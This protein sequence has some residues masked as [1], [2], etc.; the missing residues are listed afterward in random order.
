MNQNILFSIATPQI[1]I[2][3][4]DP[5]TSSQKPKASSAL[6]LRKWSDREPPPHITHPMRRESIAMQRDWNVRGSNPPDD[7]G[8]DD[9]V[10]GNSICGWPRCGR[11]ALS[12]TTSS[13][14]RGQCGGGS[15]P[16]EP[17]GDNE[18]SS[19]SES[20]HTNEDGSRQG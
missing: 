13:S 5:S 2:W 16:S 3:A 20:N 19:E 14:R 12:N 9:D 8:N 11:R 10:D 7:E 6:C 17:S 15:P 4:T 18:S 1:P